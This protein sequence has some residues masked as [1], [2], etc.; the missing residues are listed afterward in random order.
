M[1]HTTFRYLV[2]IFVCCLLALTGFTAHAQNISGMVAGANERLSGAVITN[3]SAN[4]KITS[5]ERGMFSI[6]VQKGD[7]L[8]TS[9][10]NYK[11]DTL[12]YSGQDYLLIRLKQTNRLLKQVDIN[13]TLTNP[14]NVYN[15]NKIEYKDI[16]WKGD[17]SKIIS[18]PANIGLIPSIG[19]AV[20]IDKLYNALSKQGHDAR[21]LQRNLL[22]D[23]QGSIVDQRFSKSLV[24]SITGYTGVKLDDFMVKYRPT[25][26]FAS[27]ASTY[28]MVEYIRK[29]MVLEGKN[30]EQQKYNPVK[31]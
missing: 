6:S 21:R 13:D 24:G 29:E 4:T 30:V 9:L 3:L 23:Y 16:F 10:F 20:N 7:T 17:K 28:D 12:V 2:V 27:K 8:L 15:K 5:D 26:Q 1:F 11:T 31:S 19:I 14:L 22:D 18:F 25:Y